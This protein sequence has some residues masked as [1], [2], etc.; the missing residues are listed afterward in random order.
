VRSTG[1][2]AVYRGGVWDLGGAAIASPSG[3]AT[4]D[5]PAR[6]TIDLILSAMRRHGLIAS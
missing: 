3:G 2:R 6:S 5:A 4:V 1:T